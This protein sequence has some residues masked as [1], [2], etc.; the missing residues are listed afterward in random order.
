MAA[1]FCLIK[2]IATEDTECTQTFSVYI[3]CL[4][5]AVVGRLTNNNYAYE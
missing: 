1:F 4:L 2:N 3:L 5:S